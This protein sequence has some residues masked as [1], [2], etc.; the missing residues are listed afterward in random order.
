MIPHILEAYAEPG[1][2]PPI[3]ARGLPLVLKNA[4]NLL[5]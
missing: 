4:Q 5:V 3:M 2:L 1:P